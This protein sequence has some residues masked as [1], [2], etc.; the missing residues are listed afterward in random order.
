MIHFYKPNPKNT[1]TACSFWHN[2]KEGSFFGSFIKQDSWNS[3]TRT[4]SFSKNKG[5]PQKEVIIKFSPTE[6]AELID[7]ID[8]DV[9]SSG[10]HESPKQVVRFNFKKYIFK[11]ERRGFSWGATKE[12]KDDAVNKVSFIIG[13]TFAE[14]ALLKE[15]LRFMLHDSWQKNAE[16][17][18]RKQSV[19]NHQTDRNIEMKTHDL[20]D[21][22]NDFDF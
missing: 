2:S 12:A 18:E 21:D 7:C 20:E 9:E 19:N 4:G 8:R 11:E 15:H 6:M 13:L 5:N 10:Y 16:E 14:G 22:S 17:Y 3:K 1:G